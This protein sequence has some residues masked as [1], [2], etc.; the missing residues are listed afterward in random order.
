MGAFNISLV[1]TKRS[2]RASHATLYSWLLGIVLGSLVQ[3]PRL[4]GPLTWTLR[5]FPAWQEGW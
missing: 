3:G 2:S 5:K 4:K 1:L